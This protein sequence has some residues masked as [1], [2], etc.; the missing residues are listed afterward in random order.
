MRTITEARVRAAIYARFSSENQREQSIIDQ[1]RVCRDHAARN[2]ITVSNEH[3]YT[4]EAKSSSLR[5]RPGLNALL[6]AAKEKAFEC[7]IIDDS[8]RL[9]RDNIYFN[10]L[11]E[12]FT[13]YGVRL[14]SV[15]DGLDTSSEHAKLVYPLRTFF[16]ETC[17]VV[18]V[19]KEFIKGMSPT[20]IAVSLNA[21]QIPTRQRQVWTASA[22]RRSLRSKRLTSIQSARRR[23]GR[24]S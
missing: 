11:V 1:I 21:E 24:G 14:M 19:F 4:D 17:V 16:N 12:T 6:D 2:D 10:T 7:V 23:R 13:F 8:S 18:R 20:T 15:S 22:V 9:A 5:T 3:I